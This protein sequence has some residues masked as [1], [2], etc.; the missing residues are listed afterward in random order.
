MKMKFLTK[1]ELSKLENKKF[2]K[3]Y[4]ERLEE[5]E[6]QYSQEEYCLESE[7]DVLELFGLKIEE[8]D[9]F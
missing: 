4:I 7:S 1:E 9:D 5:M 6:K 3:L 2:D 8:L